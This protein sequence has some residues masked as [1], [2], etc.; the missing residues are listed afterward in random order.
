MEI[1]LLYNSFFT[2]CQMFHLGLTKGHFISLAL[3]FAVWLGLFIL[4]GFGIWKMAKN[5][6]M[7]KKGLAFVP[8]ANY[9]YI[10]KMAGVCNFFSQKVKK[11]GLFVMIAQIIATVFSLMLLTAISYLFIVEGEP[12]YAEGLG[13]PYWGGTGFSK[14]VEN[15]YNVGA[16]YMFGISI[17]SILQLVYEILLLILTMGLYKKY[18]PKNYMILS[19]VNVFI[20]MARYIVI[21]CL[22]NK[23][24][25]DYEAYMR[26]R[27]EA[28]AREYQQRYGGA[29]GTPYGGTQY[30]NPYANPYPQQPTPPTPAPQ[31][32]FEEFDETPFGEFDGEK[33]TS[34]DNVTDNVEKPNANDDGF[35]G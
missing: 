2:T 30:N 8:F 33:K 3:G 32:P 11:M 19:I 29:Y 26:A 22:R 20:P 4:Q 27:R 21:F 28:M 6:G 14:F 15:F 31:D 18:A 12:I 7:S 5:K 34:T 17:I 25:I 24:E 10:G 13:V 16:G 35:F 1:F 9:L 23:Q